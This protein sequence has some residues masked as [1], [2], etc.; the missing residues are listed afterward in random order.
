[1]P[2]KQVLLDEIIPHE[3]GMQKARKA[4][5]EKDFEVRRAYEEM[6][7]T[8]FKE[9]ELAPQLQAVTVS[10]EEIRAVYERDVAK[11]TRPGKARLALINIKTDRKTTPEKLVE[12]EARVPRR[13]SQP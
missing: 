5:L 7:V 13:V 6:L 10:A 2:E 4:G 12:L 3:L 8:T 1:M 11:Y 9:R